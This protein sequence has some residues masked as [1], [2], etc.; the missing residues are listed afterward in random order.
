[1]GLSYFRYGVSE[2]SPGAGNIKRYAKLLS[3]TLVQDVLTLE[4]VTILSERC[5]KKWHCRAILS[6]KGVKK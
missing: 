6:E 3:D 5:I 2:D 4:K 1:M